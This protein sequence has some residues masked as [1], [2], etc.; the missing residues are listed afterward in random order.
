MLQLQ[1]ADFQPARPIKK[2]NYDSTAANQQTARRATTKERNH[3]KVVE[4]RERAPALEALRVN[5][6][7]GRARS[8]LSQEDLAERAQVSR[9]TISRI[10]RGAGDVK[11]DV[12]QRIADAL[13]VTVADLFVPAS[14]EC[15][16]DAEIARR[17]ADAREDFIDADALL[18][19]I[20]ESLGKK[21]AAA[22]EVQRYSRAGRPA[23]AR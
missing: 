7:V 19:A 21:P 14:T 9:P 13:G 20:D 6:I 22:D 15:V 8:R 4:F 5:L 12:V 17:A 18:E 2:H 11:I 16:D 10:E 23:V 1:K 3:V